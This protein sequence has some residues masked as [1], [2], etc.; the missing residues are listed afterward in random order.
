MAIKLLFETAL[1]DNSDTDIETVGT[2]RYEPDGKLYKWVENI[3]ASV[4]LAAGQPVFYDQSLHATPAAMFQGVLQV[5]TSADL[6]LFAGIAMSAIPYGEYGWIQVAGVSITALW[7]NS[8]SNDI[9]VGA[10]LL[11]VSGAGALSWQADTAIMGSAPAIALVSVASG[12]SVAAA[13]ATMLNC[14][15]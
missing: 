13:R 15:R 12:E 4:A 1:T 6:S 14:I 11:L 7:L 3:S 8:C 5:A 2:L 10:S 9:P